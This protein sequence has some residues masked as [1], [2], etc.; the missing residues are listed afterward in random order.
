MYKYTLIA[1][2]DDDINDEKYDENEDHD[3]DAYVCYTTN[4]C[5]CEIL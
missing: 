4:V 3:K 1:G 5:V 2:A